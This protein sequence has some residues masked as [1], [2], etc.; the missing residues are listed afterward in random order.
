M[1][2]VMQIESAMRRH[3]LRFAF[4]LLGM[5]TFASLAAAAALAQGG[6]VGGGVGA[7]PEPATLALLGVAAGGYGI[8]YWRNR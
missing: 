3:S 7:V 5:M 1:A 2:L 4:R 6:G 8:R